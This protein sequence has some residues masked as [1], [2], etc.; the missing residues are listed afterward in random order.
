MDEI[1]AA[2]IAFEGALTLS[3]V[4]NYEIPVITGLKEAKAR[5]NGE[6]SKERQRLAQQAAK[7]DAG[8]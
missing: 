2:L 7:N 4:L 1:A 5:I 6:I 3:D 8:K